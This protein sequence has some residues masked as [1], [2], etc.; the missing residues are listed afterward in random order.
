M[1][2]KIGLKVLAISIAIVVVASSVAMYS[3][4]D[5][6]KGMGEGGGRDVIS[7]VPPLFVEVACASPADGGGTAARREGTTFLEEEAGIS[8]YV[9][10]GQ[11]ID[12]EKAETAFKSIETANETYIIGQIAL[13]GYNSESVAPHAYVHK[14]GWIVTYYINNEPVGKIV[15]W[16]G[17]DWGAITTTTLADT[18]R[19]VCDAITFDY[20][21]I[22]DDIKYYDFEYPNANR[23]MM[24]T[25]MTK[26]SDQFNLT[27]PTECQLYEA[28]WLHYAYHYYS[29][30]SAKAKITD[31]DYFPVCIFN[32][33][34]GKGTHYRYGTFTP[35]QLSADGALHIQMVEIS[36]YDYNTESAIAIVLIY[37]T[38]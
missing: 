13:D 14:D 35:G 32:E 1:R 30:Y 16:Y 2:K 4:M 25:E 12:L 8:A 33:F 10:V 27:I 6:E 37:R 23:M 21:T 34:T 11:E 15:Q 17:H 3:S 5:V 31:E 26:S 28:S 24:I 29:D 9:N 22:E 36:D 7:L 18:I 19:K 20:Y 38:S